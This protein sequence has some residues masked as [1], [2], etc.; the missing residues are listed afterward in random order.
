MVTFYLRKI[1]LFLIVT[2]NLL[3]VMF[4]VSK[5]NELKFHPDRYTI[6]AYA[7]IGFTQV[8]VTR[9]NPI[10]ALESD[11]DLP[12]HLFFIVDKIICFRPKNLVYCALRVGN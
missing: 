1:P 7:K 11:V 5:M 4:I 9:I 12:P 10:S 6:E 3:Y 2:L 8:K